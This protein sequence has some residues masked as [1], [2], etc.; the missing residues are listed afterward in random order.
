M[1][2]LL[3][4]NNFYPVIVPTC[5]KRKRRIIVHGLVT[6]YGPQ[7][8]ASASRQLFVPK[9]Q[10]FL[11]FKYIWMLPRQNKWQIYCFSI[12]S[13]QWSYRR[14]QKESDEL[15]YTALVTRYGPRPSCQR[16]WWKRWFW[17][18]MFS[19]RSGGK[20]LLDIIRRCFVGQRNGVIRR[21]ARFAT[22]TCIYSR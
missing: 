14:V 21:N 10:H 22:S 17:K 13:I 5:S 12:I 11:G 19:R 15:L 4:L 6:R 3:L 2:N 7:S 18:S 9:L 20:Q 8:V 1:T 16:K